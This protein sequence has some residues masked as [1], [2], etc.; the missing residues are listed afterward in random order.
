MQTANVRLLL[1]RI[2][3]ASD[4]ELPELLDGISEWCWPRGDLHYWSGTLNRFDDILDETVRDYDLRR[5][6]IN[7]F[8]PKRKLLLVSLLRFSRLLL[9]NCTNRKLY[10]SFEVRVSRCG[11]VLRS[12]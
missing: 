1:E 4:D 10:N 8:T 7:D 6:Q 11:R 12:S 9:E 5:L 3:E 2:T